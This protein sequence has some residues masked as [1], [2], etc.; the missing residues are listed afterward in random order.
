MEGSYMLPSIQSAERNQYKNI[1][2]EIEF[3]IPFFTL[4]GIQVRYLKISEKSGYEGFPW[5][6]YL[7]K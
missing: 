5:V 1:P 2:I 4:S 3:E 7:I 6:R